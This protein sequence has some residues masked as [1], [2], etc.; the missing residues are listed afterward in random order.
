MS[1]YETTKVRTTET[2][3][4]SHTSSVSGVLEVHLVGVAVAR[5]RDRLVDA[6]SE[7]TDAM[8]ITMRIAKIQTRS[9]TCDASASFGTRER[10]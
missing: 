9:W 8:T 3:E 1:R 4:V 5:L 10:G 7:T 6:G 2:I